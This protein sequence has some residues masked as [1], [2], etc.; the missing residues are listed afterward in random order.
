M[1]L[2]YEVVGSDMQMLIIKLAQGETVIAEAG[3][4]NY[5]TNGVTFTVK[6]SDGSKSSFGIVGDI[7]RAGK[8]A[9]AK[10]SFFLTHFTNATSKTQEVA[11]SAPYPG[12]IVPVNLSRDTLNGV[13]ICQ[14]DAFLCAQYGTRIDI[15]FTKRFGV[16]LFG[17]EGF[18][19]EKLSG[20]GMV[21]IHACGT[22]I[23]KELHNETLTVDAGCI[24][25]FEETIDYSIKPIGNLKSVM[26]G[27]EGMF[28][29]TL[30][31]SGRVYL[32][33]LPF[34]RLADRIIAAIPD[35]KD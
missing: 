14:K 9:L 10:E 2:N 22:I 7:L 18:V 27:G 32:Q 21:F 5:M 6:T 1:G 13:L 28:F 12:K 11:F 3:A 8:R 19:L 20:D 25:G 33:S 26:F 35:K 34:S 23:E 4:M 15:T 17:G 29:A 24:V 31:G 30:S 16:G